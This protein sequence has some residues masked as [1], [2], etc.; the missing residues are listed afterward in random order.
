[1]WQHSEPPGTPECAG[2]NCLHCW[3]WAGILGWLMVV[4]VFVCMQIS[5]DRP[6]QQLAVVIASLN[7]GITFGGF[8]GD[9]RF[10][11]WSR[12]AI[13]SWIA[14]REKEWDAADARGPAPVVEQEPVSVYGDC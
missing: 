14:A 3:R 10:P 12:E 13:A 8:R 9:V 7:N 4:L 11:P 2:W 6:V 1:M 5:N